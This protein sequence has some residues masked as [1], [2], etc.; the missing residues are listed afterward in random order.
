MVCGGRPC[1]AFKC[2]ITW[3]CLG[4]D[5]DYA[6]V[7]FGVC[8]GVWVEDVPLA[9]CRWM[10]AY[11]NGKC[12]KTVAMYSYACA[13]GVV[14]WMWHLYGLVTI[15]MARWICGWYAFGTKL[16]WIHGCTVGFVLEMKSGTRG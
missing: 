6:L 16:V 14:M 10:C 5:K 11:A 8:V 15:K 3:L 12:M 7:C 2:G 9:A 4:R 1:L 13:D